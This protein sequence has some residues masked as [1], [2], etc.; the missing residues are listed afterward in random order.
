M[1]CLTK[2]R[3]KVKGIH[4]DIKAQ[5]VRSDRRRLRIGRIEVTITP[6]LE[7]EDRRK[8]ARCLA[9]FEDFCTV[10]ASI[11]EGI[12]IDVHVNGIEAPE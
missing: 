12:D 11:R 4:A 1:F 9:L 10:T 6:E 8:A 2:T 3:A 5:S 7:V